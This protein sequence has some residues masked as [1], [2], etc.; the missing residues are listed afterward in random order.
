MDPIRIYSDAPCLGVS[1]A[2]A[3]I[4]VSALKK[5][6]R[7]LSDVS[8]G[9]RQIAVVK[10]DAYG[11]SIAIC[12]PALLSEGCDFFA[13]S[14]IEEAIAVRNI[15]RQEDKFADVLILGYT[16]S[17]LAPLLVK[18]DIIQTAV[19]ENHAKALAVS[20]EI[21]GVRLRTHIAL[22]TGM[23][24]IGIEAATHDECI[25]AVKTIKELTAL[26]GL[27]IEGMF[28]HFSRAD[29]DFNSTDG[30]EFTKKQ[31]ERFAFVRN[32]LSFDGINLF[33]HVSN[34]AA[35]LRFP[36]Y[37]LDG[38]RLGIALY[39][40]N[41][42][43]FVGADLSPVMSFKTY[44]TRINEI[45]KGERVGYGGAHCASS[46][47]VIATLPIGYA[48][49]FLRAFAGYKVTV[50]TKN[51]DI[52]APVIGRICMDQC[53]IDISGAEVSVGDIVTVFGSDSRD[54]A[55]LAQMASTIEYEVLC[56]VSARVPRIAKRTDFENA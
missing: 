1:K 46:D 31:F 16:D 25:S 15:C 27:Q 30:C 9:V 40:I 56:L 39:G 51:G 6:Y 55:H 14:C 17:A 23:N 53:L 33:C 28:T 37:A 35:T 18:Y 52:K 11:H 29:E 5:N 44:V 7:Y 2:L 8:N 36:E 19:G 10:A 38:V 54:R 13:V 26:K 4:D 41:P 21:S 45:D 50:H 22:D 20:A 42:S 34:S 49:G 47:G 24:R 48:D 12:V 3:E 43:P 32:S